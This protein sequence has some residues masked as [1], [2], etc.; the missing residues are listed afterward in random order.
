MKKKDRQKHDKKRTLVF[1][2]DS[3]IKSSTQK[4]NGYKNV[5]SE[6]NTNQADKENHS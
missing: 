1:L 6:E 3:N 4:N 2:T 5:N